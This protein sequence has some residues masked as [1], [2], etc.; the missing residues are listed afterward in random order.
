MNEDYYKT[1]EVHPEA[2][3]EVIEKAYRALAMRYHPDRHAGHRQKWAEEKFKKLSEAY[4]VLKDPFLRREYDRD[5]RAAQRIA[6]RAASSSVSNPQPQESHGHEEEAYFHYQMGLGFF[7]KVQLATSLEIL[8]GKQEG[9]L[10]KAKDEFETVVRKYPQSKYSE[11]SYYRLL[12]ILNKAADH[13]EAYLSKLEAQFEEFE[14]KYP[15]GTWSAEAKLENAR[16]RILKRK[17]PREARKILHYL[18]TYYGDTGLRC[19][20]RALGEYLQGIEKK[21]TVRREKV[22]G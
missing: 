14:N 4:S 10:E 3:I 1:L 19:E 8:L 13:S 22:H 21:P 2:G 7:Q 18:E 6:S 12:V 9:F 15:S 20:V 16:F 11:E 5:F 17:D